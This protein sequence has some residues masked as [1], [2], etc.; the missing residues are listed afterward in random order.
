MNGIASE[1]QEQIESELKIKENI[2]NLD[3]RID[4]IKKQYRKYNNTD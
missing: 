4:Q 2:S 1:S 3:F